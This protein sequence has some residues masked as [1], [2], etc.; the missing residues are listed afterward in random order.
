[1]YVPKSANRNG[2]KK[3]GVPPSFASCMTSPKLN[4][5]SQNTERSGSKGI[6]LVF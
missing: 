1:M 4:V 6:V 5:F 3:W 2:R